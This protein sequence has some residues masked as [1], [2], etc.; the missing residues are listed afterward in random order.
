MGVGAEVA[1][2]EA[3]ERGGRRREEGFE[4]MR[5]EGT[6]A[7]RGGFTQQ[8]RGEHIYRERQKEGGNS[9]REMETHG[10]RADDP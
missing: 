9:Q 10:R 2:A 7:I 4:S 8:I 5:E 3:G 1:N 6:A